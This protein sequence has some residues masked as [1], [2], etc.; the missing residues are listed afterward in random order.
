MD[1]DNESIQKY[2]EE[3]HKSHSD[4][5]GK[6]TPRELV[7]D[8]V[9]RVRQ[10]NP[11]VVVLDID[12][13]DP[14][15]ELGDG[16]LREELGRTG[17]WPLVL[18]PRIIHPN[19]LTSCSK[20]PSMLEKNQAKAFRTI[21]EDTINPEKVRFVHP[22]FELDWLGDVKGI[23]PSL[24]IEH[25]VLAGTTSLE[26]NAL[27]VEAVSRIRLTENP[28][29]R[30]WFL[31]KKATGS[32]Q[33]VQFR[34]GGNRKN[35]LYTGLQ[36]EPLYRRIPAYDV[37]DNDLLFDGMAGAIVIIGTS[38]MGSEEHHSTPLGQMPGAVVHANIMLQLQ[39][40][41]VTELPAFVQTITKWILCIG[42]AIIHARVY[43]YN[44]VRDRSKGV[45]R[46]VLH[47][48]HFAFATILTI[49]ITLVYYV[50][51]IPYMVPDAV[52]VMGPIV[53][54]CAEV[55]YETIKLVEDLFDR[56]ADYIVQMLSR[57]R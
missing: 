56:Y 3:K 2:A 26:L 9:R 52:A 37:R 4:F 55:L 13:R 20:S 31:D 17:I 48:R 46:A 8:L 23:C 21:V 28:P 18:I 42:L 11:A 54:V 41:P 25:P 15:S 51:I 49:G 19:A 6:S 5:V 44:V 53:M 50:F 47:F 16:Q 24:K 33:R 34:V 39:I 7:A 30:W 40:G 35:S 1:I 57:V 10:R 36:N 14:R 29:P 22:Y 32:M 12:L 43:V 27:S 38:H 45:R